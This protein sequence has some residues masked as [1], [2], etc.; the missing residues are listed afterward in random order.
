MKE[1]T[2]EQAAEEIKSLI[3]NIPDKIHFSAFENMVIGYL[4]IDQ[5]EV[6]SLLGKKTILLF[7]QN[8]QTE[9]RFRPTK[10]G[11]VRM[12]VI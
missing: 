9:A 3:P 11:N 2:I 1:M 6:F 5:K 10:D 7:T 12:L 8:R 4:P